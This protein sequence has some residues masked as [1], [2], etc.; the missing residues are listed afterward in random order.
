M[1][2]QLRVEVIL[3][4]IGKELAVSA[5]ANRVAPV[6][7]T[8]YL[9]DLSCDVNFPYVTEKGTNLLIERL[10]LAPSYVST[11]LVDF[12]HRVTCHIFVLF[13]VYVLCILC[14]QC[15]IFNI[16]SS[17]FFLLTF[18]VY[19]ECR[20]SLNRSPKPWPCVQRG[21]GWVQARI[22]LPRVIMSV[23][24]HPVLVRQF[25]MSGFCV[26]QEVLWWTMCGFYLPRKDPND[27]GECA[28]CL[29]RPTWLTLTPLAFLAGFFYATMKLAAVS[30]SM[31]E[32]WIC[33]RYYLHGGLRMI[34]VSQVG[35]PGHHCPY[36]LMA[37]VTVLAIDVWWC[38]R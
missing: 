34:V 25:T 7:F 4:I 1:P 26:L 11:G 36:Q 24:K 23:V 10:L 27:P 29:H 33:C 32:V 15:S 30:K 2:G 16:L 13:Y 12:L 17:S 21:L 20:Q 5:R 37:L 22:V 8:Y 35:P 28:V 9:F 6:W 19:I 3:E 38:N 14:R 18:G 31:T